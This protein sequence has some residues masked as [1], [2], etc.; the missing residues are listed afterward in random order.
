MIASRLPIEKNIICFRKKIDALNLASKSP[1]IRK[2]ISFPSS[3][4]ILKL[5]YSLRIYKKSGTETNI[6]RIIKFLELATGVYLNKKVYRTIVMKVT[7][8]IMLTLK[9]GYGSKALEFL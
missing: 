3:Q 1:L 6:N 5:L 9:K 4:N 7:I 8:K 2:G